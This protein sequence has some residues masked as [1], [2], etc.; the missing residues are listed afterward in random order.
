MIFFKKHKI[1][2]VFLLLFLILLFL[3]FYGDS[4]NKKIEYG[5]TF[6]QDQAKSLGL[7]W[8]EVYKALLTDLKVKRIRLSA[9]WDK[10][11]PQKGVYD[12]SDLDFMLE[13]AK[14]QNAE[15]VLS[16]GRRLPRWPEC[17]DPG[18]IKDL[19]PE[20]LQNDLLSFIETTV[21]RYQNNSAVT[22][23]QVENEPFLGSFGICPKPNVNV[24]DSE[25]AMVKKLD[26]ARP[27]L[28]SDSGELSLWLSA[29]KRGDMFGTTMYRYVYNDSFN[30]YWVSYV[31]YWTYRVRAGFLRLLYGRTQV[32]IIEL[33]SEPWTTKGIVNTS[34]EEQFKTMSFEKFANM[35][36]IAK[37]TGFSPQYL[38]GVEWWYWMKGQGHGEYWDKAKTLFN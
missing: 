34:L 17:H 1:F 10:T 38:W 37:A 16:V 21:R 9:Y 30:M 18:W 19:S 20:A 23:W 36:S 4:S 6:S 12:F 25:I 28:I 22:I 26:P 33:Q 29:G 35:L 27:I 2:S 5:V 7:N 13:E 24:L 31:P 32:V 3:Y 14:K 8:Q 15:V 11:E